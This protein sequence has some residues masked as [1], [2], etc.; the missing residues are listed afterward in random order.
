MALDSMTL[1]EQY[2][3]S[4]QYIEAETFLVMEIKLDKALVPKRSREELT[5][6]CVEMCCNSGADSSFLQDRNGAVQ[7]GTPLE[8]TC[9]DQ[10]RAWAKAHGNQGEDLARLF[11]RWHLVCWENTC[12]HP[13]WHLPDIP[14]KKERHQNS[15][16]VS[17]FPSGICFPLILVDLPLACDIQLLGQ[18]WP[19]AWPALG[20]TAVT[21]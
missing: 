12:V 4:Q 3:S 8:W 20:S 13:N 5:S 18:D 17:V 1:R 21:S 14:L 2:L 10:L 9:K 15:T 6:R 16:T 7:Q 11:K 19:P